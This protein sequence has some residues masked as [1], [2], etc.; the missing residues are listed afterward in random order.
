MHHHVNEYLVSEVT[1]EYRLV[2]NPY[3]ILSY[4][5]FFFFF[6]NNSY[7]LAASCGNY[8]PRLRF[9]KR[10]RYLTST[11]DFTSSCCSVAFSPVLLRPQL[12]GHLL[13][14]A[15]HANKVRNS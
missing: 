12:R 14:T 4:S 15:C 11:C 8:L 1:F 7:D 9:K 13:G 6:N 3:L 5:G 2:Q 10:N